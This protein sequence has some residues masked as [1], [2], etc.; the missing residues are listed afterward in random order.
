MKRIENGQSIVRPRRIRDGVDM[1]DAILTYQASLPQ[2][3]S[4][5]RAIQRSALSG[6][7]AAHH[8]F[9]D[10]KGHH[11]YFNSLSAET[12]R[13]KGLTEI[14][15]YINVGDVFPD[16]GGSGKM[17]RH[18]DKKIPGSE[19]IGRGEGLRVVEVTE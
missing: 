1:F 5:E 6:G 18:V 11:Y 14:G 10:G 19:M 4:M 17:Y 2:V 7:L 3:L 13:T 9:I 8:H 16:P 15:P 12:M